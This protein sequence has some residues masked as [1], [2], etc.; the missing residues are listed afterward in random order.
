MM[1]ADQK[2]SPFA[3]FDSQKEKP[4]ESGGDFLPFNNILEK[5]STG[6]IDPVEV[7]KKQQEDSRKEA[8]RV[9]EE[10]NAKAASIEQ[11]A[12]EKG[13]REGVEKGRS[14]GLLEYEQSIAQ[15]KEL[16]SEISGRRK[17]LYLEYEQDI[18]SLVKIMVERLVY[19]SV[20]LNPKVVENCLREAISLVVENAD[21]QVRLNSEDYSRFMELGM[22]TSAMLKG[23]TRLQFVE[24]SSISPGGCTLQT[25]FG[26]ID[27]TIES[28]RDKLFASVDKAFQSARSNDESNGQ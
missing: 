8:K 11:E 13:F 17:N 19:Q 24:D 16:F 25:D 27:A 5:T 12:Y 4:K 15:S 21:V 20:S 2:K 23:N 18:I 6:M 9:V 22:D 7:L 1:V 26:E 10:A 28:C 14:E 3:T